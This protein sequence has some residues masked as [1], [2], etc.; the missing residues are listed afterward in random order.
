MLAESH[1]ARRLF[2]AEARGGAQNP[3]ISFETV[4]LPD[5]SKKF[6]ITN[7]STTPATA[8]I[9][10]NDIIDPSNGDHW[11]R[12]FTNLDSVINAPVHPPPKPGETRSVGNVPAKFRPIMPGETRPI[13]TVR[14]GETPW[15][16]PQLRAALFQDGAGFGAPR[17]VQ[18]LV[19]IRRNYYHNLELT[20]GNVQ[21]VRQA[22]ATRD[23]LKQQFDKGYAYLSEESSKDMAV[24]FTLENFG[25]YF[26]KDY[27]LSAIE[28]LLYRLEG[29]RSSTGTLT[30]LGEL[31]PDI[32]NELNARR[33]RLLESEPNILEGSGS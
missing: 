30:P 10:T 12:G 33:Q 17:W 25:S 32:L 15:E 9:I 24:S 27:S 21:E 1:L 20:I 5:G 31:L 6:L 8:D 29:P 18:L 13:R 7:D 26:A 16:Q 28:S 4:T 3:L 22:G 19:T 2:G 11:C 14:A 23:G